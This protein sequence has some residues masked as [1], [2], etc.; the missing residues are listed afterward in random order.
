MTKVCYAKTR[1]AF[2]GKRSMSVSYKSKFISNKSIYNN[3]KANPRQIQD[4]LIE[5]Q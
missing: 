5:T 3:S 2:T 1:K 4:A